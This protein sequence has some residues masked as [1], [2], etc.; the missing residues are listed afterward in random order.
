MK[1]YITTRHTLQNVK[2]SPFSDG[3]KMMPDGNTE[4]HKGMKAPEMV[5]TWEYIVDTFL[6]IHQR[7]SFPS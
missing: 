5:T 7:H 2:G 3:K 4:V 1:E 6:N